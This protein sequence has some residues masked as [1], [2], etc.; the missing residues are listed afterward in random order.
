MSHLYMVT[1]GPLCRVADVEE[2]FA[3]TNLF[4]RAVGDRLEAYV[5]VSSLLV[6]CT[7]AGVR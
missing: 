2:G 1:T 7:G 4:F 3:D 5:C 6:T